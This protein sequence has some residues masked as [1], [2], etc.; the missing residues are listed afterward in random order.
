MAVLYSD[1]KDSVRTDPNCRRL[2]DAV[3]A[4]GR[5]RELLTTSDRAMSASLWIQI[6][7]HGAPS[8][9]CFGRR[10]RVQGC[11]LIGLLIELKPD[12][13]IALVINFDNLASQHRGLNHA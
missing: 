12:K 10:V 8:R 4:K 5:R 9:R 11:G 7:E 2:F 13:S 1:S 3:V 6:D